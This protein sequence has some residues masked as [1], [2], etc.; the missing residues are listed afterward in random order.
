MKKHQVGS[1]RIIE[2]MINS[3]LTLSPPLHYY[4]VRT[5]IYI[6]IYMQLLGVCVG[7]NPLLVSLLSMHTVYIKCIELCL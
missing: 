1:I 5:Y 3:L 2:H 4:L 7:S 6:Y